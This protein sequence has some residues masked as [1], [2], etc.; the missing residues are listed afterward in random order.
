[1]GGFG[2]V[3]WHVT[4]LSA[5]N[6]VIILVVNIEFGRFIDKLN[7]CFMDSGIYLVKN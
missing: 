3:Q 7:I 6:S 4:W 1:M 2:S 5:V